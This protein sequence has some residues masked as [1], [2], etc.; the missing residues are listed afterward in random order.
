MSAFSV[1]SVPAQM[2]APKLELDLASRAQRDLS[3]ILLQTELDWGVEQRSSYRQTLDRALT[4]LLTFPHL[5]RSRSDISPGLR[6][7]PAGRH[8]VYYRISGSVLIVYR[9]VHA[10]MELGLNELS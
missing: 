5:G 8:V 3:D 9:I 7:F 10:R 6:S 2:S 1:V 4:E